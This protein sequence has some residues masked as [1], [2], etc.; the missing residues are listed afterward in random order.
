MVAKFLFPKLSE[1]ES[2]TIETKLTKSDAV[3]RL[4]DVSGEPWSLSNIGAYFMRDDPLFRGKIDE[5]GFELVLFK[6]TTKFSL[7]NFSPPIIN[8]VWHDD[9]PVTIKADIGFTK[10]QKRFV[11]LS[12]AFEVLFII[13][14]FSIPQF[15]LGAAYF[16]HVEN[17]GD[18]S[19]LGWSFGDYM[20]TAIGVFLICGLVSVVALFIFR[21]SP[22]LLMNRAKRYSKKVFTDLFL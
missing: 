20:I 18:A 7:S 19:E 21:A 11:K 4:K 14:V 3:E 5:D 12:S 1:A 10:F 2:V 16:E 8:G 15:G 22:I 6:Y 9:N 13:F 17:A